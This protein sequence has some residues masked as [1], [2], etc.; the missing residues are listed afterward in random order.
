MEVLPR[1]HR[2]QFHQCYPLL[3]PLPRN[4]RSKYLRSNAMYEADKTAN[5]RG[6]G[7]LLQEQ[8]LVRASCQERP[9]RVQGQ[10]EGSRNG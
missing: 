8:L 2:V 10:R 1:L 5:T 3:L 7:S 4:Q 9:N 6:N